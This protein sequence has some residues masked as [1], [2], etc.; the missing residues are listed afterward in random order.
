MERQ[1]A[2][3]PA[4]Q[5]EEA[6]AQMETF[7]SLPFMLATGLVTGTIVLLLG[8]VGQAAVLYFGALVAGGEVNFGPVFTVSVW[9]R[10]PIAVRSVVQAGFM[11]IS[12][13]SAQYLGLAALVATGDVMKDTRNPLVMLLVQLDLFW[14]WHLLLVVLGLAVVARFSRVKSLVLTLIYAALSLALAVIPSLLFGGA[15]GG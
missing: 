1:L 3:M 13:R 4:G 5:A 9:T 6:R 14:L 12:G 10:L 7:T 15:A 11:T 8:I 2:S